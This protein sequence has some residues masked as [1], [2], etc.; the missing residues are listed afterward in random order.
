MKIE[1]LVSCRR[2]LTIYVSD[3]CSEILRPKYVSLRC[4]DNKKQ[5][6]T[7]QNKT[8]QNKTKQNKTKQTTNKQNKTKQTNNKQTKNKTK[9]KN[10]S[11]FHKR[12]IQSSM[13][14]A[15]PIFAFS[16]KTTGAI[17]LKIWNRTVWTT[18]LCVEKNTSK[19]LNMYI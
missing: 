15:K 11:D 19:N 2:K 7:K 1:I 9:H 5:N 17:S 8:K 14:R 10:K 16:M 18:G 3:Y 6:K 12:F 13:G 4:Y